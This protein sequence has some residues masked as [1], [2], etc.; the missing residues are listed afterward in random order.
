[1]KQQ[2]IFIHGGHASDSH[3]EY[4]QT[5]RTTPLRDVFTEP[6]LKWSQNLRNLLGE[7]F[8][9]A[10]PIMP[11]KYHADYEIWKIWFLRYLEA[12]ND[13]VILVG[14]SL[15]GIFLAKFLCENKSPRTIAGLHLVAA[16]ASYEGRRVSGLTSFSFNNVDLSNVSGQVSN[17]HLYH[18]TDDTVVPYEHVL[19]FQAAW[20]K[21]KLHTFTDRG[22]FL[23]EDFPE[24]VSFIKE[25][26]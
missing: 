12:C 15:G 14:H 6:K 3:E 17:I 16:V 24:L 26:S 5:L 13:G 25:L 7:A 10:M 11:N 19:A 22:H 20:P 23:Q 9:V 2:V 4:L 1:M 21:A 18:S 8:E